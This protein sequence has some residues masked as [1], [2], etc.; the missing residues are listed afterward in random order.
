MRLRYVPDHPTKPCLGDLEQ[1]LADRGLI[2]PD[3][4][5]ARQCGERLEPEDAL[6][7]RSHAVAHRAARAVLATGFGDQPSLDE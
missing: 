4:V 2:F 3:V 1:A 6:E 7:E 5:E